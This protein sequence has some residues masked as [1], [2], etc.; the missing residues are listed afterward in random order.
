MKKSIVV[1]IFII[2]GIISSEAQHDIKINVLGLLYSNYSGSYEYV[3]NK[4]SG[5]NL[6]AGYFTTPRI[7]K[8]I[9]ET[10]YSAT[11]VALEYRYYFNESEI[12]ASGFW[13]SP[14]MKYSRKKYKSIPAD[15]S[16]DSVSVDIPITDYT[17]Q[18]LTLGAA[19]G[20]KFAINNM[21]IIG[22]YLGTGRAIYT[23]EYISNES[24]TEEQKDF[25]N[26]LDSKW[27][28]RLGINVG[29]RISKQ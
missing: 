24:L 2:S 9:I 21:I 16:V 4:R 6:T 12:D 8:G 11:G 28:F 13:V 3:L 7:L 27:Q 26:K 29:F 22:G 20:V 5:I 14:Y 23:K 19:L 1:F 18:K 17:S 15:V 10:G 25:L